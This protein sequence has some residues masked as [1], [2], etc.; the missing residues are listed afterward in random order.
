MEPR[1]GN[2]EYAALWTLRCRG[3][4]WLAALVGAGGQKDAYVSLE[5]LW[6]EV[7]VEFHWA[8]LADAEG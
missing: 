8:V 5:L 2:S 7:R 4:R 1:S 6:N 3:R